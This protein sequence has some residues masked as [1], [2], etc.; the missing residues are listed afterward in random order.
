[1]RHEGVFVGFGNLKP[2]FLR[3]TGMRRHLV[4]ERSQLNGI[5]Y[6]ENHPSGGN[7]VRSWAFLYCLFLS[8]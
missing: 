3:A 5:S 7:A 2:E 1:M 6:W 4:V 8:T